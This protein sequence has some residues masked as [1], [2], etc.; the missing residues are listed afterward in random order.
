M[1]RRTIEERLLAGRPKRK[2]KPRIPWPHVTPDRLCTSLN[3]RGMRVEGS[4]AFALPLPCAILAVDPGA[5]SGWCLYDRGVIRAYGHFNIFAES[6]GIEAALDA[7]L[8]LP[9]PHVLVV[10]RPFAAK[11]GSQSTGVGTGDL[12]WRERAKLRGVKR[13]VRVYPST[14]RSRVLPAGWA[15]TKKKKGDA[16]TA[17]KAAKRAE[18]DA[19]RAL[20]QKTALYILRAD[21]A[22]T[23]TVHPDVAPSV[24]IGKWASYAGE[25]AAK[26]PK[27]RKK[28]AA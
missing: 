1:T 6:Q 17:D 28:R 23:D 16:T 24:G 14:W 4:L 9:G 27:G 21:D 26:L 11:F 22:S 20:E 10:E 13:H 2:P 18:R 5:V 8:L 19:I 25:V 7:L 15:G 3:A 12:T